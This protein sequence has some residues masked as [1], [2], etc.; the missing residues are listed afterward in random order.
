VTTIKLAAKLS[1]VKTQA[2]EV[3]ENFEG[4]IASGEYLEFYK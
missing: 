3:R 4:L 2:E 1:V